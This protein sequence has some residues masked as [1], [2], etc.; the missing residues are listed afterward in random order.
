NLT[1]ATASFLGDSGDQVLAR[2]PTNGFLGPD[3]SYSDGLTFDTSAGPGIIAV[4]NLAA[5]VGKDLLL[6]WNDKS[7]TPAAPGPG[8]GIR[9]NTFRTDSIDSANG[10]TAAWILPPNGTTN[11]LNFLTIAEG[12]SSAE[13]AGA[14]TQITA[15]VPEPASLAIAVLGC[16]LMLGRRRRSVQ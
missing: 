1:Q 13:L 5:L 4:P 11:A 12:G 16:G 6:V 9:F 15:A 8:G 2:F 7:Y 10:S 14:T 3:N